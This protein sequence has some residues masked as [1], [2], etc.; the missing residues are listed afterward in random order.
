MTRTGTLLLESELLGLKPI[1]AVS[2]WLMTRT[3]TLGLESELLGL[4]PIAAVSPWRTPDADRDTAGS[5][6]N[7]FASTP[8]ADGDTA[9]SRLN[10]FAQ[11]LSQQC[12][13]ANSLN[14]KAEPASAPSVAIPILD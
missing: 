12:P 9:G 13:L 14:R 7:S 4:K 5:S 11:H 3:G 6:P 8:D 10:S 1:A 2:A